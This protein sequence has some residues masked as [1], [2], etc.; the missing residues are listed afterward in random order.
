LDGCRLRVQ[1]LLVW[2]VLD[3]GLERLGSGFGGSRLGGLEPPN[4]DE[5]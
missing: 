5:G 3:A 4:H 1:G 2:G